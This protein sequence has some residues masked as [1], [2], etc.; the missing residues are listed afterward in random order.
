M[1]SRPP[2]VLSGAEVIAELDER[3]AIEVMGWRRGTAGTWVKPDGFSVTEFSPQYSISD[4]WLIV[5]QMRADG[6]Q[7]NISDASGLHECKFVND[8]KYA[9]EIG[10]SVTEAIRLA[11]LAAVEAGK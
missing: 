9:R 6:W 5:E 1:R 7:Y 3:I 2:R 8:Q 10:D 4:A 11:A